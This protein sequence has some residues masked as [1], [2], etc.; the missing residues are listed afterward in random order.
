MAYYSLKKDLLNIN[1]QTSY[2]S[3]SQYP[4]DYGGF[5]YGQIR[6]QQAVGAIAGSGKCTWY[7]RLHGRFCLN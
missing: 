6:T 4:T 5:M 1:A 7:V 2:G 3:T